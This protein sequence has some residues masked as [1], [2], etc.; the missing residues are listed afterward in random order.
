LAATVVAGWRIDLA[1]TDASTNESEFRVRRALRAPDGSY[2]PYQTIG[3]LR[4]GASRYAD[5]TAA[6]GSTYRY[7]VEACNP[8]GCALSDAAGVTVPLPPAAPT[9]VTARRIS[10]SRVEVRWNDASTNETSFRVRR[11]TRRADGT[12]GQYRML[13]TVAAGATV[14]EDETVVPPNTYHYVVEACLG[15]SCSS[16]ASGWVT[17]PGA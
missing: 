16:S 2:P 5:T 15:A 14:F 13:G 1:W 8:T 3:T 4:P 11:T 12:Y 9:G 17:V 10:N 6:A 7:Q